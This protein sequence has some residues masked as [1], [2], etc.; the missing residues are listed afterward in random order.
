MRLR[1]GSARLFKYQH[2]GIGNAKLLCLGSRP[3][4]DTN[5]SGFALQWNIGFNLTMISKNVT[6]TLNLYIRGNFVGK[7]C[8]KI[9]KHGGNDAYLTIIC[10]V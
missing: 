8:G 3:A 10:G 2:V 1:V 4:R 6:A 7:I 9:E 5:M